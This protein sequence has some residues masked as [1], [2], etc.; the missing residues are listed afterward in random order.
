[1]SNKLKF[2][3]PKPDAKRFADI[4]NSG[5]ERFHERLKNYNLFDKQSRI[6]KI[7]YMPIKADIENVSRCNLACK[8]CL[9]GSLKGAKR[10]DDLSLEDYKRVIDEQYGL[11]EIK[12]Q[13]LGEPLLQKEFPDMVAYAAD[14]DIWVRS[15]TNGMLL[16][17]RDMYK[18]IINAGIG[19]LQVSIDGASKETQEKIRINS[20]FEILKRNCR[21]LNEYCDKTGNDFTRMWTV[22][23]QENIH[24][25]DKFLSTAYEFGFKRVTLSMELREWSGH[26]ELNSFIGNHRVNDC[27]DQNWVDKLLEKAD[28]MGINL[29][30]WDISDRFNRDNI[31]FWPFERFLLS[32][33]MKLVPCCIIASPE[34]YSYGDYKDFHKLWFGDVLGKFRELHIENNIVDICKSCYAI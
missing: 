31:C 22:L 12:L 11:I 8:H 23:Q 14:R 26:G 19:E 7:D 1:M 27:L 13:G 17:K 34:L 10:A 25:A 16:D 24:E 29:T 33:D 3:V 30:F 9:V 28:R 21:L 2:P 20:D 32:S 6:A 18:N 4:R 15:T 5:F